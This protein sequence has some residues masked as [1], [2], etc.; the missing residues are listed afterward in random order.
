MC[1]PN[2]FGLVELDM[3]DLNTSFDMV[4]L[5]YMFRYTQVM[6]MCQTSVNELV[7]AASS[8]FSQRK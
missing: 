4:D 5:Q 2:I 7:R 8:S 1:A 6:H 3:G